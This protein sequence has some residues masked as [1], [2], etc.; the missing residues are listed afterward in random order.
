M[1]SKSLAC[2]SDRCL[3]E[4]P[5]MSQA[6]PVMLSGEGCSCEAWLAAGRW[7][8]SKTPQAAMLPAVCKPHAAML[9]RCLQ[10][11]RNNATPLSAN[12]TQQCYPA[13]CKPHEAMLPRCLQASRSNATPLS[14]NLTQQCY[15]AVCKPH[16]AMLPRCLQASR[17]NA[18]PLSANQH[19]PR[20]VCGSKGNRI[21]LYFLWWK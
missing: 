3:W 20:P 19:Q 8:A 9:P 2:R 14:A 17:N 12:L 4:W 10:A 16:A 21:R 7:P 11:S 13:V 5:S 15:P 18:T 6:D 1:S